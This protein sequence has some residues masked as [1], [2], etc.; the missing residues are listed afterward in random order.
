[1]SFYKKSKLAIVITLCLSSTFSYSQEIT[2][3]GFEFED[4]DGEFTIGESPNEVTFTNGEAKTIRSASF[5][6]EGANSWM[7]DHG[8]VA[9]ISFETAPDEVSFYAR[10]G[11]LE[12][13]EIRVFDADDNQLGD[14]L[15]IGLSFVNY[16]FTKTEFSEFTRIEIN[17]T[18]PDEYLAVDAFTSMVGEMI[19]LS[20][21]D[22]FTH[23]F[24]G[25]VVEPLIADFT[26]EDQGGSGL[27]ATFSGGTAFVRGIG[28]LYRTGEVAW[29]VDPAG[30]SDLGTSTGTG[31]ILFSE[32]AVWVRLYAR[33]EDA[34]TVATVT[35]LDESDTPIRDIM[36]SEA[37]GLDDWLEIEYLADDEMPLVAKVRYE[38]FGSN[39]AAIDDL[40]F[41]AE[42]SSTPLPSPS[43]APG[44][45]PS[46][47]PSPSPSP[48]PSPSPSP[49]PTPSAEPSP[50]ATPSPAPSPSSGSSDNGGGSLGGFILFAL[51]LIP[52]LSGRSKIG[53]KR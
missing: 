34:A 7:I 23:D 40:E 22:T 20:M 19:D 29:M 53:S 12:S 14:T 43:P 13:G 41:A 2:E 8:D 32:P 4:T 5:Y 48:E 18:Q 10:G 42:P 39:V 21:F 36:L 6:I 3:T 44:P 46:P 24:E 38:N 9:N 25:D 11:F 27:T 33:V 17:N 49:S 15:D 50:S 16:S 28:C 51:M 45:T 31:E 30:E 26:L 37:A 52:L 1:M 35:L 47:E